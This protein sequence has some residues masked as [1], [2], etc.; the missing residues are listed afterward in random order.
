MVGYEKYAKA[1]CLW[2]PET[3]KI[4]IARD[5]TFIESLFPLC[6]L[7]QSHHLQPQSE[8]DNWWF[9]FDDTDDNLPPDVPSEQ[10]PISQNLQ[11]QP[12]IPAVSRLTRKRNPVS[13][14]GNL[15]SYAAVGAQVDDDNGTYSQA[16]KGPNTKQWKEAMKE[17]FNSLV[18]HQVGK[19]V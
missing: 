2:N 14:F 1:Y 8:D 17:E 6:K 11:S 5:V 12:V 9:P 18:Q 7:K 3:R 15:K 16:M 19:L 13:C 10:L 4:H